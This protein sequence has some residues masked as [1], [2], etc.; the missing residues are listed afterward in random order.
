MTN[1]T[2][3]TIP[4]SLITSPDGALLPPTSLTTAEQ[5][6]LLDEHSKLYTLG[7]IYR[8]KFQKSGEKIYLDHAIYC[9]TRLLEIYPT[10]DALRRKYLFQFGDKYASRYSRYGEA[11]DL[12][13][14]I[15]ALAESVREDQDREQNLSGSTRGKALRAYSQCLKLRYMVNH[16]DAD[17]DASLVALK[18]ALKTYRSLGD[19]K[20]IAECQVLGAVLY[21]EKYTLTKNEAA[22]DSAIAWAQ[23][24]VEASDSDRSS[25]AFRIWTDAMELLTS[26]Y[27]NRYLLN[28]EEE[29]L[30]HAIEIAERLYAVLVTAPDRARLH[31][32][33]AQ[34]FFSLV[35]K[36][37]SQDHGAE[38]SGHLRGCLH[39]T[40]KDHPARA[41]REEFSQTCFHWLSRNDRTGYDIRGRPTNA[42]IVAQRHQ[43]AQFGDGRDPSELARLYNQLAMMY[44]T[45][46]ESNERT[47]EAKSAIEA[48]KDA[49]RLTPDNEEEE[50]VDRL[51]MVG[52]FACELWH[53]VETTNCLKLGLRSVRE[54][55]QRCVAATD[56]PSL[57]KARALHGAARLLLPLCDESRYDDES[58]EVAELGSGDEAG[59]SETL[60]QEAM[61]YAAQAVE[62]A[63]E[64]GCQVDDGCENCAER[65][66]YVEDLEHIQSIAGRP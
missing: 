26:L 11:A 15:D 30:E 58:D 5:Q 17:F 24:A 57:V 43:I 13:V 47:S 37:N 48:M 14:A 42:E 63:A 32:N 16:L 33:L 36:T 62:L 28:E 4:R 52:F 19:E 6:T 64:E 40:P 9:A 66:M 38:V 35:K 65:S 3:T 60:V 51:R 31:F 25:P 45:R 49:A 1:P 59:S 8:R 18:S 53:E 21:D 56:I 39:L 29:D 23:D 20:N 27:R 55:A 41:Q 54:A 22:I 44:W 50:A 34:L 2:P 61:R 10:D 46:Y 7:Q 12:N